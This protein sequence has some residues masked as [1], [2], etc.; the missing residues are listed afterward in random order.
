M[1]RVLAGAWQRTGQFAGAT[2]QTPPPS[3]GTWTIRGV[4]RCSAV[5]PSDG[6]RCIRQMSPRLNSRAGEEQHFAD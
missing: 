5:A 3:K 6:F 1:R 2:A 4:Q